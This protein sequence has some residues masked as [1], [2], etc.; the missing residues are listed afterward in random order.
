MTPYSAASSAS[1]PGAAAA[2]K[3]SAARRESDRDARWS[4]LQAEYLGIVLPLAHVGHWLWVLY[5][6]PVA[7]VV[8]SLTRSKLSER[9]ERRANRRR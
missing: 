4:V 6:P 5:L 1:R 3:I 8:F 7:I 9:S 2:R